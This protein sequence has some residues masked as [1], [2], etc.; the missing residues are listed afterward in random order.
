MQQVCDLFIIGGGINGVAIAADAAGRGL[1]VTLCEKHDLASG[2]SSASTK[3]I[4]GGLRYL[5]LYEFNLVRKALREREILLKRAPFLIKPLEFILPHEKHLRPAWLIRSGLFLYNHLVKRRSLR[6]A[7]SIQLQKDPRGQALLSRFKQGFSY[8][9]GFTDDAR[10]VILNALSA[11]SND[12]TIL[13]RTE[14]ISA[15]REDD[16]W[17]IQLKNRITQQIFYRYAKA[18]IN[19]AGPWINQIGLTNF[20]IKLVKGSHIVVPKLYNGNFAYILQREDERVVF[21]IPYQENFTLIGTTD[22]LFSGDLDEVDITPEESRYLLDTV[23]RYF[24]KQ[25]HEHDIKWSYAGVR[26]LQNEADESPSKITRD[27]K[28]EIETADDKLPLLTV[29]GGKITTHRLLAE[30]VLTKLKPFFREIGPSWTA[31][32]V[33]P[34]AEFS[35]ENF[36]ATYSWLPTHLAD[37]YANNYGSL[38]YLLLG[39][40]SSLSDL[41]D[42]FSNELYEKEINY[43]ITYEWAKT[44]EDILW[45]RTKLGLFFSEE[46]TNTLKNYLYN[47][48]F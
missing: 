31:T 10:L 46:D 12:A 34:G 23:N 21:A 41:G 22:V 15:E 26:C 9:D 17:K 4:H 36:K 48:L 28:L 18:L 11:K 2:T 14:F 38:A 5:E 35:Y 16:R 20:D 40:A 43:L 47:K 1:S 3:L 32:H 6:G 33:L 8:Y 39:N 25:T 7:K 24:K 44:H 13:T 27:Y 30:D 37:R 45:R 29:I 42:Y 19:A